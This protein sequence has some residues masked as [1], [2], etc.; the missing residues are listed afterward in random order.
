MASICSSGI[1]VPY[2][3]A[4]EIIFIFSRKQKFFFTNL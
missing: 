3:A 4:L 2:R 1:F